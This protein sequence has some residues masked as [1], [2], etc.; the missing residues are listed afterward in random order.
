MNTRAETSH[1]YRGISARL[2]SHPWPSFIGKAIAPAWFLQLHHDEFQ[3]QQVR[4]K[5]GR[6]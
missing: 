3:Y 6:G 1:T 5:G 4:L 2:G